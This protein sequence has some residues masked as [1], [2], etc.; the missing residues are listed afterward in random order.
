MVRGF[1]YYIWWVSRALFIVFLL[2]DYSELHVNC[3][4]INLLCT[5]GN[6][7]KEGTVRTE[8]THQDPGPSP[9]P[10]NAPGLS[11]IEFLR[12]VYQDPTLPMA[13]RIAA[14]KALLPFT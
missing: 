5:V 14:A 4:K 12:A 1:A 3:A 8:F 9:H 2:S 11:P 6:I 7:T 13:T 10:C